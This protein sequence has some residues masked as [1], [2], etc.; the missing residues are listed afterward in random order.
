MR[1]GG[2]DGTLTKGCVEKQFTS[3]CHGGWVGARAN[4]FSAFSKTQEANMNDTVVCLLLS[5]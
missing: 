1:E 5:F 4:L 3:V 2:R